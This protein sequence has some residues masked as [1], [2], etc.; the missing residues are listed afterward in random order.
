LIT[1][2][3]VGTASVHTNSTKYFFK[4]QLTPQ[5]PTIHFVWVHFSRYFLWHLKYEWVI[6]VICCHITYM[7]GL[8]GL[9]V[10]TLHMAPWCYTGTI[11]WL[12][13]TQGLFTMAQS[14]K[15]IV[16][17]LCHAPKTTFLRVKGPF[18]HIWHD[19]FMYGS[20]YTLKNVLLK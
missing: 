15:V 18:N 13:S 5:V 19:S 20:W 11:S 4:L 3:Y 16:A 12:T 14:C 1:Y 8:L 7:N 17:W 6:R 2:N 10:V 9:F